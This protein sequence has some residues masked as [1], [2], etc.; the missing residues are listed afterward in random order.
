MKVVTLEA[1]C[2]EPEEIDLILQRLHEATEDRE[3]TAEELLTPKGET[4]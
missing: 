2:Y 3:Y 4:N 1:R